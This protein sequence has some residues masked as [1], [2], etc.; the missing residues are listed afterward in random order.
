LSLQKIDAQIKAYKRLIHEKLLKAQ[1]IKSTAVP[2]ILI[3]LKNIEPAEIS[4]KVSP[5]RGAKNLLASSIRGL[6]ESKKSS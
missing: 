2:Q 4:P 1:T 3:E 6:F 5:E